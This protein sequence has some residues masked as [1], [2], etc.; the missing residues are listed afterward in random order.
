MGSLMGNPCKNLET[1]IADIDWQDQNSLIL[2]IGS[3]RDEGS[4]QLLGAIAKKVNAKFITVDVV[5][6]AS[7]R[8]K[9]DNIEFVVCDKG[10]SWCA[11]KLA[12]TN[13][14]IKILFL[15]N[16]DWIWGPVSKKR[17]YIEQQIKEYAQRGVDMN[18]V[19]CVQEHL[20]QFMYCLP[21]LH[22]GS[23]V[24][25]DD[26]WLNSD[27]NVYIGKCGPIVHYALFLGWQIVEEE[28]GGVI[29]KNV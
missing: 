28:N 8:I 13:Y 4:T 12:T 2:E 1:H 16:F 9:D 22:K 24:V 18:N 20:A 29:I 11:N 3:D 23:L 6:T 17:D 14:N 21:K 10:S 7:K 19:D 5:D 26:T 27:H 15:D 25:C